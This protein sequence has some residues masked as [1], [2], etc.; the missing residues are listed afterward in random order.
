MYKL[1]LAETIKGLQNKEFSS[2]EVT[3]HYLDRIKRLDSNYNAYV[4]VTE[5]QALANAAQADKALSQGSQH[6]LC[7]VPFAHKD[8]FCTDGVK[9][10]C[11]SKMLDNFIAP[12][13]AT[14]VENY[15]AAGAVCLGKTNMD[16]FAM[17]GSTETGAFGVTRN[18]WDTSRIPGGSSGGARR[19][20]LMDDVMTCRVLEKC[21]L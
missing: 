20:G 5:E 1:T 12:Y 19:R 4:T 15:K 3:Q 21:G 18:P 8:I 17:G 16:E 2:V 6:A 14:V 13:D 11:G 10:T 9:T 7:G